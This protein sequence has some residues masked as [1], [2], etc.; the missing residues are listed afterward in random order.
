MSLCCNNFHQF[1]FILPGRGGKQ[2]PKSLPLSVEGCKVLAETTALLHWA[3]GDSARPHLK[4]PRA[5]S[6]ARTRENH[7]RAIGAII[8][9]AAVHEQGA[10]T[11][12]Q[13]AGEQVCQRAFGNSTVCRFVP[14]TACRNHKNPRNAREFQTNSAGYHCHPG[15]YIPDTSALTSL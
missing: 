7:A 6:R 11:F 8:S 12:A 9:A 15:A 3:T 10:A 5:D 2:R 14:E 1:P 13:A 4:C